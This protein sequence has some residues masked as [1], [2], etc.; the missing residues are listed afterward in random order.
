VDET[1]VRIDSKHIDP[2]LHHVCNISVQQAQSTDSRGD[3]QYAL[4][5]FEDGDQEEPSVAGWL[6]AHQEIVA[7]NAA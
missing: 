6:W 2:T 1:I 3:Q 5:E 7:M 4:N